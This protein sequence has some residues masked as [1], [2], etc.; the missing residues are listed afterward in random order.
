MPAL[1]ARTVSS[2]SGL[3]RS[4]V[5]TSTSFMIA[6]GLKKCMP[7][8][9]SGRE[10][11]PASS[12]IG[13]EEVVV[14]RIAPCLAMRSRSR[15]SSV[16]TARSSAIASTTRST[17]ASASRSVALLSRASTSALPLSSSLPREIALSR[18]VVIAL[19]TPS[20]FSVERP[21]MTTS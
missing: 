5:T 12:V 10:V 9:A 17:S 4:V 20:V 8:T 11:T 13:S 1:R 19:T 16:L 15:K 18:D 3:V 7:M 2:T 21:T 6:A 14:L